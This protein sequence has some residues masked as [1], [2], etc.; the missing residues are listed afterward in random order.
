MEALE[1]ARAAGNHG[2]SFDPKEN[3]P[4]DPAGEIELA[5]WPRVYR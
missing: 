4:K 5:A 1:A 2:L 3:G